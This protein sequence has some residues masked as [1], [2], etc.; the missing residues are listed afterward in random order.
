MFKHSRVISTYEIHNYRKNQLMKLRSML[1]EVTI[2]QIPVL[3]E[4]QR[5][6]NEVSISSGPIGPSKSA[7][8]LEMLPPFRSNLEKELENNKEHILKL[9]MAELVNASHD[10]MTEKARR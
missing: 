4:F 3:G 2:D 7:L 10:L 6:L 9:Q 8:I 5:W 1:N